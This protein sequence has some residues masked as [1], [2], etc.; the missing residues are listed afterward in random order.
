MT[1]QSLRQPLRHRVQRLARAAHLLADQVSERDAALQARDEVRAMVSHE[2]KTPLGMLLGDVSLLKKR[3]LTDDALVLVAD[4]EQAATRLQTILDDLLTLARLEAL[5]TESEPV[6]IHRSCEQ[7]IREFER[8]APDRPVN[9]EWPEHLPPVFT[10]E[11]HV[12]HIMH[13]LLM[14]AHKYSP[15]GTPI[16]VKCWQQGDD[17]VV[18]VDDQGPGISKDQLDRIFTPFFRSAGTSGAAGAGLGLT[19][20]LRLV[21]LHQGKIW[22]ERTSEGNGTEFRFSFPVYTPEDDA[23]DSE[24]ETD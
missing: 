21:E 16:T 4:I 6:L 20:C 13:N 5:R 17:L 22:V 12:R 7:A 8:M 15:I 2:L 9:R 24:A 11:G 3:G 10:D 1:F 23:E 19:V 14:N 18:S